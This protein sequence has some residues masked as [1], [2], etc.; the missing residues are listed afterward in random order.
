MSAYQYPL[1]L[2]FK[3]VAL[4]PQIFVRDVQGSELLYV[5]Q[6]L[7]KLKEA[8]TAY[9]DS[10]KSI[11]LYR[12]AADRVLDFRARY[13]FTDAEGR[14]V[15]AVKRQGARSLW[16]ASYDVFTDGAEAPELRIEEDNPWVKMIDGV[17]GEVP[18]IGAFTGYFLNPTY[19]V[20]H[21]TTGAT[22]LR[23]VKQRSF[24]ES[25]FEIHSEGQMSEA[26]ERAALL[27]VLTMVLLERSRG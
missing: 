2:T 25:R 3:I 26:Q 12:I 18:V 21:A 17:L 11:P 24:L 22:A 6:K 27:S 1:T 9:R 20:K 10:S 15:G 7:F 5:H 14:P 19:L 16:K 8:I 23:V 13:A 4:A